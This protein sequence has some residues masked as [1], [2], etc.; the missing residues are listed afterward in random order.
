MRQEGSEQRGSQYRWSSLSPFVLDQLPAAVKALLPCGIA[1][2]D[3]LLSKD[4]FTHVQRLGVSKANAATHLEQSI[5]ES[6]LMEFLR[7]AERYAAHVSLWLHGAPESSKLRKPPGSRA[8][9]L[10][11]PHDAQGFSAGSI[12][13]E[14]LRDAYATDY[15]RRRPNVVAFQAVHLGDVIKIDHTHV[16]EMKHGCAV[17]CIVTVMNESKRVL[18]QCFVESESLDDLKPMFIELKAR[19]T[20]AGH[21]GP[22]LAYIDKQC[23]SGVPD[24]KKQHK[25]IEFLRILNPDI[26]VS[27]RVAGSACARARDAGKA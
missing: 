18:K 12:T 11:A 23:C 3:K 15:K 7:T 9:E 6:H 27:M 10:G 5:R 26:I 1:A 21:P 16:A 22:K 24:C 8:R 4:V 19:Y 2:R 14:T 13:A 20:A 25:M 17:G